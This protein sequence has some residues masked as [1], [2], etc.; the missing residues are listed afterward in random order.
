MRVGFWRIYDALN[1]RGII[2]ESY[3]RIVESALKKDW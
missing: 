1:Q 3:P 2:C